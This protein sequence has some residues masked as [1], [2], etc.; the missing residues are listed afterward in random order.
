MKG[1]QVWSRKYISTQESPRS[2]SYGYHRDSKD[3]IE[4]ILRKECL[5][6]EVLLWNNPLSNNN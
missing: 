1:T 3:N 6:S 2:T 5:A 4:E